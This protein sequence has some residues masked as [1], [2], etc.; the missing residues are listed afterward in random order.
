MKSIPISAAEKIAKQYGYSQV[1]IVARAVGDNGREVAKLSMVKRCRH[2]TPIRE[3]G[4][5]WCGAC[6]TKK[7]E[8]EFNR[9]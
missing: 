7:Q 5:P 8:R 2:G 9:T 6:R 3:D 4:I 1:I